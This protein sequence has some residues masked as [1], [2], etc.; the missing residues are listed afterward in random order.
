[1]SQHSRRALLIGAA[2]TA[3]ALTGCK[4]PEGI[5]ELQQPQ[6]DVPS[7]DIDT[8]PV[9][10]V[11]PDGDQ[12]PEPGPGEVTVLC[13]GQR[14]ADYQPT[15]PSAAA[16]AQEICAGALDAEDLQSDMQNWLDQ[17]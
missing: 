6:L 3:V 8:G 16:E 15:T 10:P 14:V 12:A 4:P 1:M 13:D 2:L 9:V 17:Q 11:G 7:F 5:P